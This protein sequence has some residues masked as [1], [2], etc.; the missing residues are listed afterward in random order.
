[1]SVHIKILASLQTIIN[2]WQLVF[3]KYEWYDM[4]WSVKYEMSG[5]DMK[6]MYE[7]YKMRYGMISGGMIWYNMMWCDVILIIDIPKI[8]LI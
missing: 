3:E 7:I 6:Y 5:Y 1:M 2:G 4:I 8:P